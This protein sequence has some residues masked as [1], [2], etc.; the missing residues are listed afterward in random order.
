MAPENVPTPV[1]RRNRMEELL[2]DVSSRFHW[3]VDVPPDDL[4]HM[5]CK[6]V[7]LQNGVGN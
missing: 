5:V 7:N 3:F 2:Q 6:L 1:F 4:H